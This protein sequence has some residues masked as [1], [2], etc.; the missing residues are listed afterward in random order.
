MGCRMCRVL[1]TLMQLPVKHFMTVR[2]RYL[3]LYLDLLV[4]DICPSMHLTQELLHSCPLINS[5]IRRLRW[6]HQ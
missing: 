3:L 4:I 6:K 1:I 5:L 2:A